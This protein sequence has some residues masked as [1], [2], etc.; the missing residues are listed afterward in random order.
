MVNGGYRR[1]EAGASPRVATSLAERL[2]C[3]ARTGA[4]RVELEGAAEGGGGE[5]RLAAGEVERG[6]VLVDEGVVGRRL[7]RT[8]IGGEGRVVVSLLLEGD[9]QVGPDLGV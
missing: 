6:E 8:G 2:Q 1:G 4:R 3:G 9:R 5:I 7:E